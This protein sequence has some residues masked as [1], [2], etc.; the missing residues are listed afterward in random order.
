[1]L[2]AFQLSDL[3]RVPFGYLLDFLYRFCNNY[4]LA[5]ILFTILVK[6]ILFP[7]Q[8]KAKRSMMKMSRITPRVQALQE[9]Y[10][11]IKAKGLSLTAKLLEDCYE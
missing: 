9:K 6:I 1:M 2:L 3:I 5:L 8:A 11:E 4:G 10:A 7:M